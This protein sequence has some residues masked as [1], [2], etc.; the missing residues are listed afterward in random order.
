M[1]G[2]LETGAVAKTSLM[3]VHM[4]LKAIGPGTWTGR[5]L[6]VPAPTP[7]TTATILWNP[8]VWALHSAEHCRGHW[9]AMI[10]LNRSSAPNSNRNR[11]QTLLARLV[12]VYEWRPAGRSGPPQLFKDGPTPDKLRIRVEG[13][14]G[15][16][17][18]GGC[19]STGLLC[20]DSCEP[21]A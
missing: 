15:E 1:Q 3:S 10:F 18:Y 8:M 12:A 20:H 17:F 2:G 14:Y 5:L 4:T 6:Q 16:L 7:P 11:P 9:T 19:P 13:S 21:L